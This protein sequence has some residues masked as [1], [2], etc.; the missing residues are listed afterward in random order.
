MTRA[1]HGNNRIDSPARLRSGALGCREDTIRRFPHWRLTVSCRSPGT[2]CTGTVNSRICRSP[3]TW[4]TF[5][6]PGRRCCDHP[7]F[8]ECEMDCTACWV[9]SIQVVLIR[10]AVTNRSPPSGEVHAGIT[11]GSTVGWTHPFTDLFACRFWK[12]KGIVRRPDQGD[13]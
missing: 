5:V 1:D 10:T 7:A 11:T 2:W 13:S 4:C 8:L 6:N 12:G 9:V 3:G